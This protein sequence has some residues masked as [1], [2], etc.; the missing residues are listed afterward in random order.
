VIPP[1]ASFH[2]LQ[3]LRTPVRQGLSIA[4]SRDVLIGIGMNWRADCHE[5]AA[6]SQILE[7]YERANFGGML[8]QNPIHLTESLGEPS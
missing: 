1:A 5:V 6:V 3:R 4:L 7:S 2:E 8:S